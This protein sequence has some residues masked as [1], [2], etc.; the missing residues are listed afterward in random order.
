MASFQSTLLKSYLRW[1]NLLTGD[2][3]DPQTQRMRMEKAARKLKPHRKVKV[4]PVEAGTVPS[5][6]LVP[7]KAPEDRTLLYLHGGAWF[8]GS[9]GTHRGLNG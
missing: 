8:M 1:L 2:G 7:P 3:V 4:V 5:E 6:W 9:S